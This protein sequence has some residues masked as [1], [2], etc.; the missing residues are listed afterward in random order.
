MPLGGGVEGPGVPSTYPEDVDGAMLEVRERPSPI[1]RMSMVGPW[2]VMPEVREHP[3]PILKTSMAGP[4]SR[5]CRRP[6][7]NHHLS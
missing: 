6:G 5:R 4:P 2:K 7:S 3:P 1:L